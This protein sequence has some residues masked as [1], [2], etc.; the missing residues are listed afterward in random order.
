[1]RGILFAVAVIAWLAASSFGAIQVTLVVDS[2]TLYVG[3]QTQ[4]RILAQAS[5]GLA[6]LAGDIEAIGDG[7]LSADAGSFAFAP[8][9]SSW[10][11]VAPEFAP[12]LG[13]PAAGGGW[14]GFGSMQTA[15]PYEK[16]FAQFEAVEI[17]SYTV[18]GV[19]PGLVTLAYSGRKVGGFLPAE[20]DKSLVVGTPTS[21]VIEVLPEPGTL[22]LLGLAGLVVTRRR[23]IKA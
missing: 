15:L 14:S 3:Q 9:F 16:T 12:R 10:T 5:A 19:A 8:T 22:A 7:V 4:V 18:H 6:G 13:S 11:A 2:P 23:Q 1:M 21:A 20:C 17:A